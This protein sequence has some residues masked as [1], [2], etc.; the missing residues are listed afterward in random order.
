MVRS[1]ELKYK[2]G[3]FKKTLLESISEYDSESKLF[4]TNTMDYFDDVRDASGKYNP[5]GPEQNWNVPTDDIKQGFTGIKEFESNHTLAGSTNGTSTGINYRIG[6][7][8]PTFGTF[9]NNTI[10]AHGGNNWGKSETSIVLEDIDG[11]SFPDK[12]FRIGSNV[13][14]RKNLH[15]ISLIHLEKRLKLRE[16]NNLGINK[17]KSFSWGV[18][19]SVGFGVASANVGYDEQRS[20]NRTLSYFMDFNGDGL[21]DF[22]NNGKVYYNRIVDGVPVFMPS[23][24][25]TPSPVSGGGDLALTMPDRTLELQQLL[26]KNPLQDVVRVWQAPAKGTIILNQNYRF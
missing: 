12:I 1:Y 7:G 22:V 18:D 13:Y 26:D 14:Y 17:I 2:E 23:S 20:T 6:I 19:A 24:S 4:Y 11:D 25:Q 9:K 8:L 15:A 21:V 3:A 10:G 5:F 16:L